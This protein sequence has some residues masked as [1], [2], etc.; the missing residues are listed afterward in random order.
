MFTTM[1][2]S[3]VL[4]VYNGGDYLPIALD[5]ILA[6]TYA[7]FELCVVD[8]GSTDETVAVLGAAMADDRRIR[9]QR[10]E[11]HGSDR[12]H[13]TFN[14]ALAMTSRDLIAIANADDIWRPEKLEIQVA[15]FAADEHLD[16]CFHDATFIDAAGRVLYGGFRSAPSPLAAGEPR[17][18]HFV[19]GNPIPNPTA[20]FHRSILRRIGL[21]EVGQAHDHQFWF[22]AT[23]HGCRFLGL[24]DRLIRYRLHEGSESTASHRAERTRLKHSESAEAMVERYG[25]DPLFAELA[26]SDNDPESRA[27]AWTYLGALLWSID[28]FQPA[29]HAWT[30]AVRLSDNPAT[31]FN[32]ALKRH[33][34]GDTH[35]ARQ[36]FGTAAMSGMAEA[37]QALE[38]PG[39]VADMEPSLWDGPPPRIVET[40]EQ[41]LALRKAPAQRA[42]VPDAY[43]VVDSG[44]TTA[45]VLDA[46]LD[47]IY[48]LGPDISLLALAC[49]DTSMAVFVDAYEQLASGAH[50]VGEGIYIDLVRCFPE[51]V[52]SISAAHQ[53]E[54]A[55]EVECSATRTGTLGLSDQRRLVHVAQ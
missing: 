14:N 19:S 24:A 4:Y 15:A 33:R 3:I 54:G 17:P 39:V 10:Q 30:E 49:G 40:I 51:E 47:T 22:K 20:M 41:P 18:W 9:V 53:L 26:T 45:G 25:L 48:R 43:M 50:S 28:A 44:D 38:L 37:K 11:H 55:I 7:D 42:A 29:E 36:L 35:R 27:W 21:Q 52:D 1:T 23:V 13:E 6:Q 46:L 32:L 5:S 8:D 16:V 31:L 12:L 2:V 34:D